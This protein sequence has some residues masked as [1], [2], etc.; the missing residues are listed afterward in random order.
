MIV[1]CSVC[2]STREHPDSW[3]ANLAFSEVNERVTLT[4]LPQPNRTNKQFRNN[5]G[6][7]S[8]RGY[9]SIS[10]TTGPA[11]EK[12]L[13]NPSHTRY[14]EK[15]SRLR[16]SVLRPAVSAEDGDSD[17][18]GWDKYSWTYQRGLQWQMYE[19][20]WREYHHWIAGVHIVNMITLA[21]RF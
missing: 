1:R 9:S 7:T 3:G 10:L 5:C 12:D 18:P 20:A 6:I 8:F 11:S 21:P 16:S 14:I 13:G 17:S 4:V 19:D 15:C 2:G